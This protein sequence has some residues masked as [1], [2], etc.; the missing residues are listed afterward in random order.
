MIRGL[1]VLKRYALI[2]RPK[3]LSSKS[4]K[5]GGVMLILKGAILGIEMFVFG[6]AVYVM[7]F[8]W[9]ESSN[10]PTPTAGQGE[11]GFDVFTLVRH[12][13]LSSPLFSLIGAIVIGWSIV[14]FGRRAS[15]PKQDSERSS[16]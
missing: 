15:R 10:Y 5:K 8:M 3:D 16:D 6:F 12:V 2:P 13:F 7:A 4:P 1:L 11:V 9:W 14:A